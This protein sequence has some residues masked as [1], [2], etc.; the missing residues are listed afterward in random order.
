MF[1]DDAVPEYLY[2]AAALAAMIAWFRF[3]RISLDFER[4]R[5][6]RYFDL[7]EIKVTLT[8][9]PAIGSR[10]GAPLIEMSLYLCVKRRKD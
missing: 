7:I 2:F 3:P 5:P 8:R 6:N 4:S 1:L 10:S 9:K